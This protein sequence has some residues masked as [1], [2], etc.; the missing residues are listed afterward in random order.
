M[1]P[2]IKHCSWLRIP[3]LKYQG[4]STFSS[5]SLPVLKIFHFPLRLEKTGLCCNDGIDFDLLSKK[6]SF[7]A[8]HGKLVNGHYSF[9]ATGSFKA[10][11][12]PERESLA[13]LQKL[14]R[15]GGL[16]IVNAFFVNELIP[17]MGEYDKAFQNKKSIVDPLLSETSC[18]CQLQSG[19][20]GSGNGEI[21]ESC[22]EFSVF[23]KDLAGVAAG[24]FCADSETE[25]V[26][27]VKAQTW[28][29]KWHNQSGK[30]LKTVQAFVKID[31]ATATTEPETPEP[32]L[33]ATVMLG[34]AWSKQTVKLSSSFLLNG[35]RFQPYCTIPQLDEK[36]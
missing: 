4:I 24:I 32:I 30:L 13:K 36:H 8:E 26:D 29:R 25:S 28:I 9:V 18:L 17:Y 10:L 22:K 23:M 31:A 16:I 7:N 20:L 14:T 35:E 11:K 34:L 5:G 21:I 27:A 6:G 12:G 2:F 19:I 33:P 3:G 1:W 15:K